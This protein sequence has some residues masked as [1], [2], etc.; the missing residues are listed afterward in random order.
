MYQVQLAP[1]ILA[2]PPSSP[3]QE[4][5]LNTQFT[6]EDVVPHETVG[7]GSKP[8]ESFPLQGSRQSKQQSGSCQSLIFPCLPSVGRR[9]G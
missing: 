5:L 4:E 8:T 9:S 1:A 2:H 3:A 6:G 7:N